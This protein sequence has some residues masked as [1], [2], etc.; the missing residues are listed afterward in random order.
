MAFALQSSH[1]LSARVG[2]AG[3]VRDVQ[4]LTTKLRL[5]LAAKAVFTRLSEDEQ[6]ARKLLGLGPPDDSRRRA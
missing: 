5:V 6:N 4:S 2:I 3:G 1:S